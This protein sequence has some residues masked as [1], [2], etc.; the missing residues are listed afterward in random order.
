MR[1][2]L[3]RLSS[4]VRLRCVGCDQVQYVIARG[5]N[6]RAFAFLF[7]IVLTEHFCVFFRLNM[8]VRLTFVLVAAAVIFCFGFLVP[9]SR[10]SPQPVIGMRDTVESEDSSSAHT[11]VEHL[12]QLL[13]RT[14]ASVP[15][16]YPLPKACE[17]QCP[18]V[19][20]SLRLVDYQLR[21]QGRHNSLC[22]HLTTGI[23]CRHA[24][25]RRPEASGWP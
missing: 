7:A 12:E 16:P 5:M 11:R 4:I 15:E 8:N 25:G 21:T 19:A 20:M 14:L 24:R 13:L 6:Y 9:M 10:R 2:R 18:D 3:L 23:V 22:I 17:R 1:S